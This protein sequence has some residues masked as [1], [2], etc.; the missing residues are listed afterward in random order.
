MEEAPGD[1]QTMLCEHA[2]LYVGATFPELHDATLHTN[3]RLA[4]GRKRTS[5]QF[6]R[7]TEPRDRLESHALPALEAYGCTAQVSPS[8]W[9][10]GL[11]ELVPET[12]LGA[13]F[14]ARFG[15]H[16]DTETEVLPDFMCAPHP[17]PPL[18]H[19]VA[20][21]SSPFRMRVHMSGAEHCA[22][23]SGLCLVP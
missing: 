21:V 3:I 14:L 22:P 1:I 15:K 10:S 23:Y 9:Y 5:L 20:P 13:D 16:S 19:I 12:V 18:L 8:E 11:E 7:D 17:E 2:Q 4:K 6:L